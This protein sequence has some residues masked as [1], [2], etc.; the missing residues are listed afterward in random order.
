M[1]IG[2]AEAPDGIAMFQEGES[3]VKDSSGVL[4]TNK[5]LCMLQRRREVFVHDDGAVSSSLDSD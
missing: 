5:K 3:R 1:P 2:H 4:H